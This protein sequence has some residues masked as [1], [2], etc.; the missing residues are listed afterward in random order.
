MK[1]DIRKIKKTVT[2][3]EIGGQKIKID[4]S[5]SKRLTPQTV[6]NRAM[7][8]NIACLNFINRR[9]DFNPETFKEKLYYGK[10]GLLGYIVAEDD[11]E[12]LD[13][14]SNLLK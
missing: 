3:Q 9:P 6:Y 13:F 2:H 12:S 1:E 4:W 8:G 7:N 14:F 11:L 5:V 10:V